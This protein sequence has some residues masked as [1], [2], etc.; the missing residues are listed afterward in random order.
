[1]TR[2]NKIYNQFCI[3][4][5]ND[6][7][8]SPKSRAISSNGKQL[9]TQ[10]I[11]SI[12]NY[13]NNNFLELYGVN[14]HYLVTKQIRDFLEFQYPNKSL[15]YIPY[16]TGYSLW[17]PEVFNEEERKLLEELKKKIKV[18]RAEIFISERMIVLHT[19]FHTLVNPKSLEVTLNIKQSKF[20]LSD[21]I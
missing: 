7:K 12:L 11:Y 15:K 17:T 9:F 14:Y 1:M 19:Y 10:K 5:E 20:N 18:G 4:V 16:S 8:F 6:L 3:F 21:L 2:N 13:E